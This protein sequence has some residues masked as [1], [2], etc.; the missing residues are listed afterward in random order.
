MFGSGRGYGQGRG[1]PRQG[2]GPVRFC[3]C[4][5]CGARVPHAPGTPCTSMTCP[6]CGARMVGAR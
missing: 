5:K 2:L 3:V 1:G 6:K 4:P